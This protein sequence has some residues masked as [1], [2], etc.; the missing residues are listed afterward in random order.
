L[1]V[2]FQFSNCSLAAP[3]PE[4]QTG[5]SSQA[6]SS[7]QSTD[8]LLQQLMA[9]MKYLRQRVDTLPTGPIQGVTDSFQ[10]SHEIPEPSSQSLS[11]EEEMEVIEQTALPYPQVAVPAQQLETSTSAAILQLSEM[12]CFRALIRK[13]VTSEVCPL[14]P[15]RPSLSQ[16][17][18][19]LFGAQA[20]PRP[21]DPRLSAKALVAL[22]PSSSVI[23]C[24]KLLCNTV[25]DSATWSV[26]C[27]SITTLDS[28]GPG[29]WITP[30]KLFSPALP[31]VDKYK[32]EYYRLDTLFCGRDVSAS[33]LMDERQ[34][35]S[36]ANKSLSSS[37]YKELKNEEHLAKDTM[38]ECP[39]LLR[40]G[41][42]WHLREPSA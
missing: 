34:I 12:A 11:S 15:E 36:I 27:K 20:P 6:T 24:S 23:D 26:G 4:I 14:L 40:D 32:P 38:I 37:S 9:E 35:S 31:V 10:T 19:M 39:K 5:Y 28:C 2:C 16:P 25:S 21:E 18:F 33:F 8:L 22:P 7:N 41:L 30:G 3:E 13:H 1:F 17:K 42:I 29:A